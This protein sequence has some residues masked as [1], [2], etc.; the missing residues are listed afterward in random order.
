[1][2]PEVVAGAAEAAL[3]F[4]GDAEAAVLADDVVD[5]LEELLAAA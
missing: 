3:H 1:M 2:R 4:V 5:D